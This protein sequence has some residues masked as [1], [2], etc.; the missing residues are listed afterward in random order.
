MSWALFSHLLAYVVSKIASA[1]VTVLFPLPVLIF[2]RKKNLH[3]IF[4]P[5]GNNIYMG[6]KDSIE[7]D[8]QQQ[9]YSIRHSHVPNHHL[10]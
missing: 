9:H 7:Y 2:C 4:G 10:L 3:G 6:T 5:I 8:Q 1:K